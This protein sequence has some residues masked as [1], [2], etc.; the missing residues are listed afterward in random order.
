MSI[1]AA[2]GKK[3]C[4]RAWG[5]VQR[6]RRGFHPRKYARLAHQQPINL[7]RAAGGR[8]RLADEPVACFPHRFARSPAGKRKGSV[9][10]EDVLTGHSFVRKRPY[11]THSH[12]LP[13]INKRR[14]RMVV[15]HLASLSETSHFRGPRI[16]LRISSCFH[17]HSHRY[18]AGLSRVRLVTLSY[19]DPRQR[20]GELHQWRRHRSIVRKGALAARATSRRTI[21]MTEVGD[22]HG[23]NHDSS[24][25]SQIDSGARRSARAHVGRFGN[26]H[27]GNDALA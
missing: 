5:H 23:K 14:V 18:S 22:H 9:P 4:E 17:D 8:F 16:G 24:S 27:R 7:A 11:A 3:R 10:P 6:S 19:R 1:R 26:R 20:R 21:R 12:P 25:T 13:S 2:G 15:A